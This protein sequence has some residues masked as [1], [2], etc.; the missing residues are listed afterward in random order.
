MEKPETQLQQSS[1]K[2]AVDAIACGMIHDVNNILSSILGFAELAKMGLSI[3]ANVEKDLDEI[4]NASLRAR[5]LVSQLLVFIRRAG[6]RTMPVAVA[7]LIK[8]TMKL[9]RAL[10]PAAIEISFHPGDFKGKILVDPVQFH[11]ILIILCMNVSHAMKKKTG[12][13]EIRLKETRLDDKKGNKYIDLK[14][15]RYL[16]LSVADTGNGMHAEILERMYAPFRTPGWEGSF[17]G[18]FIAQGLAR[19]MGGTVSARKKFE[20]GTIFHI[21]LPK[22]VKESEEETYGSITDY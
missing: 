6:I 9:L 22:Y 2:A 17:P 19:E 12:Q 18:L 11:H 7:L 13:I 16:Q 21:L 14:P 20:K 8:E 10:L 1:Q 3:G 15:G 4:L 5:E